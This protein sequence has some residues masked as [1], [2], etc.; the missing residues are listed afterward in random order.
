MSHE[1]GP[2]FYGNESNYITFATYAD[3]SSD[4]QGYGAI[5]GDYYGK[6][7]VA[8]SGV[9]PELQPQQPKILTNLI[10]WAANA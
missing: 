6:G 3:D 4:Y 8:L 7:R 5:V 2:A 10:I 1:N 9:H